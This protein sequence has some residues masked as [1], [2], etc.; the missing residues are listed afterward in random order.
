MTEPRLKTLLTWLQAFEPGADDPKTKADLV[1]V[2]SLIEE[3]PGP[4]SRSQFKPGHLTASALVLSPDGVSALLIKH[5]RLGRW[6]QPGGH[7]EP[8]D[9]DLLATALREVREETGLALE[10]SL[11]PVLVGVDIHGI[12]AKRGEPDHEHF[13]I[14][15]ALQ[16]ESCEVQAC[17]VET[18]GAEWVPLDE[19]VERT[20]LA[21]FE[22]VITR[23]HKL[24]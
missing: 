12:P 7:V 21:R 8:G 13:D 17:P 11:E 22:H 24:S 18:Q 9:E 1:R 19:V 5:V 15:F 14:M 6:L 2:F 23:V 10:R 16:A 20:G 4:C 3:T